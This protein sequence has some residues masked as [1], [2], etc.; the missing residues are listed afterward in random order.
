VRTD[1]LKSILLGN[2]TTVK[3]RRRPTLSISGKQAFDYKELA[4]ST[5]LVRSAHPRFIFLN[6]ARPAGLEV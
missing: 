6:G 1:S 4:G 3:K 5:Q 2:A